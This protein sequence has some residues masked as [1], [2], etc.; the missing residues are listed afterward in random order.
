MPHILVKGYLVQRLIYGQTDRHTH[1][2]QDRLLDYVDQNNCRQDRLARSNFGMAWKSR[3]ILRGLMKCVTR[4]S[5]AAYWLP[6]RDVDEWMTP[7]CS[8]L[9]SME[10]QFFSRGPYA[11]YYR[12]TR[13]LGC[14][15]VNTPNGISIGSA[16]LQCSRSWPTHKPTKRHIDDVNIIMRHLASAAMRSNNNANGINAVRAMR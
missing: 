3:P 4:R 15:Q 13:F 9:R 2:A 14:T 10:S 1:I 12:P 7:F 8:V 5:A 16:I 6:R 11:K